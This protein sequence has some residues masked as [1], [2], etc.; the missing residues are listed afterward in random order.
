MSPVPRENDFDMGD[1]LNLLNPPKTFWMGYPKYKVNSDTVHRKK[2]NFLEIGD[3]FWFQIYN[4]K[5]PAKMFNHRFWFY[6]EQMFPESHTKQ[7]LVSQ[8]DVEKYIREADVIVV[9]HSEG[10]LDRFG[11][12]FIHK[13]YRYFFP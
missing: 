13:A 8:T 5:L 2:L 1:A 6:N 11:S 4:T 3:S 7:T 9:L 12:G 10:T